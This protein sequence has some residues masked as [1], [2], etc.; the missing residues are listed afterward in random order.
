MRGE[1]AEGV[2]GVHA[3]RPAS[4]VWVAQHVGG[5]A[6]LSPPFKLR[7]KTR[8]RY[9]RYTHSCVHVLAI[10]MRLSMPA[11]ATPGRNRTSAFH[12]QQLLPAT[13]AFACNHTSAHSHE[14]ATACYSF[15][16]M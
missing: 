14:T 1:A 10:N 9:Y 11:T 15:S 4:S 2:T 8:Y 7:T 5:T 16:H 13:A 6:F 12:K 3:S